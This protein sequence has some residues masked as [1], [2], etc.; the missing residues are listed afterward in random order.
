MVVGDIQTL[1]IELIEGLFL[2][3]HIEQVVFHLLLLGL[4]EW[5]DAL[6][7]FRNCG[8]LELHRSLVIL[9]ILLPLIGITEDLLNI[10][11]FQGRKLVVV[12]FKILN[13]FL[14]LYIWVIE[15]GLQEEYLLQVLLLLLFLDEQLHLFLGGFVFA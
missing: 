5:L 13:N 14:N 10:T 2:E 3:I 4:Y 11:K 8:G 6:H 15:L 9:W 1:F 12:V 7:S